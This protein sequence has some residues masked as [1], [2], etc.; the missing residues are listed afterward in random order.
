MI[1]LAVAAAGIGVWALAR[2]R[3]VNGGV[4]LLLGVAALL[5]ARYGPWLQVTL[6]RQRAQVKGHGAISFQPDPASRS[7]SK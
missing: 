7:Q 1:V 2:G 4:Y 6:E 5:R 3:Y